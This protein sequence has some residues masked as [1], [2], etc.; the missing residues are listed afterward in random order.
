LSHTPFSVRQIYRWPFVI[1]FITIAGLLFALFGDGVWDAVSWVLL[2]I[3]LGMIAYR[4]RRP[5]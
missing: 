4:L 3:P 2:A 5:T 1:A